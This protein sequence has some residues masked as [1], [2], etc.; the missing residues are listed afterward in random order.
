MADVEI[1]FDRSR[2]DFQKTSEIIKESYWGEGRTDETHH[3]AFNNSFCAAAFINGE[4]VGFARVVTDYACFAYLC[5][6]II[7]P[8]RRGEGIG[9]KLMA[10]LLAHP[11]LAAVGS[12]SLRTGDAHKLYEQFGFVTST[13]GMYM[14]LAR[15]PA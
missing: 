2:I 12:W 8:E 5:D 9:K 14:R 4:Q 1:S 6:V 15:K 3:R 13:D 11:D 10:A 7:W